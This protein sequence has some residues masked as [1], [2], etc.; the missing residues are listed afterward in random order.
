MERH[1]K[2]LIQINPSIT[3]KKTYEAQKCILNRVP[4]G[5]ELEN[6]FCM[7]LYKA[8]DVKRFIKN[9]TKYISDKEKSV[10]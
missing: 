8:N 5:N 7:F 9:D 6:N 1:F 3:R 10:G 4:V 2:E